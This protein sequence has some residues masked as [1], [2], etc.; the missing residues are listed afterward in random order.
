MRRLALPFVALW[1]CLALL[2]SGLEIGA[3]RARHDEA[4]QVDARIMHRLLSQRAGQHDAILATLALLQPGPGDAQ[5]EVARRLPAVYPQI[6]SVR[7]RAGA[8]GWGAGQ[9]ALGEAEAASRKLRR[10]VLAALDAAAGRYWL[11]QAATPA[12]YALEIDVA[13]MVP[14]EEW[15]LSRT[16][17]PVAVALENAGQRIV[18][19]AGEAPV[20]AGWLGQRLGFG[21]IM[22]AESQPFNV[23][24]ARQLDWRSLPWAR[25]ALWWLGSALAC[26]LLAGMLAQR[27]AR[28][29]AEELLRFGQMSRLNTLGELAAGLAHEL[30]QPL[31]AVSANT[32]AARRLLDDDPPE[33]ETARAAMAQAVGQARRAAEVLGRLRRAIER[34]GLAERAEVVSLPAAA[35]NVLDLLRGELDKAGVSAVVQGDATPLVAVDPVALDQIIHNLLMNAIQA[36]ATTPQ[37]QRR[38]TI[39][40]A[41]EAG[42][43][44]LRVSDSGPGIAPELLPRLFEPFFSTREGG[45]GLG[46]SLCE[47]LATSLG[48]RLT[49]AN[50]PQGGAEFRLTLPLAAEEAA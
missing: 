33:L 24:V 17:S 37:G 26:G 47:T 35:R 36:M 10:P 44:T 23:A 12:S 49:A 9:A 27:Q 34:P 25:L 6:I 20:A 1:L 13:A 31:A 45:L 11:V 50:L 15:P 18:I 3:S 4:F 48:G 29:R 16:A 41:A 40:I 5:G 8:A 2:A 22:A 39:D 46:L 19:H 14:W 28:R 32:Q 7:Q 43:A 42:E 38:L 21:K 30:N